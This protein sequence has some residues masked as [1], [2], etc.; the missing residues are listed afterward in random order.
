MKQKHIRIRLNRYAAGT[1]ILIVIATVSAIIGIQHKRT[2]IVPSAKPAAAEVKSLFSFAGLPGWRKG[3][4][5]KT[6]MALFYNSSGCFVTVEHKQGT[7]DVAAEL[8]KSRDSLANDGYTVTPIG[9]QTL[10]IQTAV[11]DQQY[12]LHQSSVTTPAGEIKLMGGQEF[13]YAQLPNGYLEIEGYCDTA[14]DLSVT[15]PALQAIN[16]DAAS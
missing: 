15:I 5:N 4:T 7:V 13:G 9:S 2:N 11:G 1:G 16:F 8:K 10:T 14:S 3:P 12:A 6:S